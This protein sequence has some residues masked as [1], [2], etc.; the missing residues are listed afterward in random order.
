MRRRLATLLLGAAGMLTAA[1]PARGQSPPPDKVSATPLTLQVVQTH[2][3]DGWLAWLLLPRSMVFEQWPVPIELPRPWDAPKPGEAPPRVFVDSLAR[4]EKSGYP[5]TAASR[6]EDVPGSQPADLTFDGPRLSDSRRVAW[7]NLHVNRSGLPPDQ[8]KG[9]LRLESPV[10]GAAPLLLPLDLKVRQGPLWPLVVILIGIMIGR[11]SQGVNTPAAQ[12]QDRLNPRLDRLQGAISQV[13]GQAAFEYLSRKLGELK[14]KVDAAVEPEATLTLAINTLEALV[15]SMI[16]LQA[17]DRDIAALTDPALKAELTDLVRKARAALIADKPD[18]ARTFRQ[19]IEQRLIDAETAAADPGA[20]VARGELPAP[21][22][23]PGLLVSMRSTAP[24]VGADPVPSSTSRKPP[25]TPNALV[26][27]LAMLAGTRPIAAS[28]RDQILR[29]LLFLVLLAV[30]ALLG[31]KTLYVEAG[32][33]FG[34]GGLYDYLGLFLWGQG[35]EVAQRTLQ[36]VQPQ[37]TA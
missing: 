18:D 3:Y 5:V 16:A 8:Y 24:A 22:S 20:A 28:T 37:R 13:L 23:A 30:L 32:G 35:A 27:F 14:D 17:L 31:L 1:G 6:R 19:Q 21:A 2:W 36:Q 7:L 34:S 26:R 11:I 15:R 9:S 25:P 10:F 33:T 12:M 29:P 4:G